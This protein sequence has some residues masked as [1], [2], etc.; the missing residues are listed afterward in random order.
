MSAE[1]TLLQLTQNVLSGLSSDEVNSISDTTESMQVATIIQNKYYD[2]ISR[3]DL[4]KHTQL[5]QLTASGDDTLPVLMYVPDNVA[6]IKWVKYFDTNVQDGSSPDT[7]EHDLNTD[8]VTSS[9][10]NPGAAPGYLY[11]TLLPQEQFLDMTNRF[12]PQ[13]SNVSSFTFTDVSNGFNGNFTFYYKNN[14]QPQYCTV[15]SNYYIFFDSFDNTQDTTLQTSKTMVSADVIP[16]F[17]MTDNFIPD[18]DP[19]QFPLLLNEAKALAYFELKQMA[20]PK[21][22]QEIKRQWSS[23]Q[24]DKSLDNKPGY[25]DQL[26]NFG[27]R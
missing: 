14:R 8:I 27:R 10:S 2:I 15:L 21:A 5:I 23:I 19:E 7:F 24:K 6:E 22:E 16:A 17:T 4:P 11:V 26:P 3:A 18:L 20:H 9:M 1:Q 13:D 25:F 12:N